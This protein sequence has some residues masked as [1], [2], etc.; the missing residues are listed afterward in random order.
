MPKVS[1]V[2]LTYNRAAFLLTAIQSVLNQ[3]FHNFEIIVVDD[4]SQDQTTEMV[5]SLTDQRIRYLRHEANKG[6]AAS[7]NTG[8]RQALGEYVAFLDDDDEWLPQKLEKQVA[9]LDSSSCRV[10]IVYTGFYSMEGS[11]KRVINRFIPEKRGYA[12]KAMC[13]RNWIG[14]PSTVLI[15]RV[16]FDK[17]GLFD[18]GLAS[19][20]DYDMWLR[21]SNEFEIDYIREPL[22]YYRVHDNRISANH[23]SRVRGLEGLLRKHA[24]FFEL[25]RKNYGRRY[26]SLGIHYCFSGNTKKGREALFR[27]IKLYPFG[28]RH[29]YNLCL[30]LFGADN[31]RRFKR[32]RDH[33]SVFN[34][35]LPRF[36]R[37]G[38]RSS[39]KD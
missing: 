22:V 29:Y 6:Q 28:V 34:D 38:N 9:L 5:R 15:R 25:D 36:L 12:V 11:T 10:G 24:S 27:A 2:I 3:T 18:E 14:T 13:Q 7:R 4:G 32:L 16:C 30:S 20:V 19:A 35:P 23:E 17:T 31:F 21:I 8:I 39:E 26:S 1:V 37:P 33:F